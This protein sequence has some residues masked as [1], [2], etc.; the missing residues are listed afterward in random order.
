MTAPLEIEVEVHSHTVSVEVD[1]PV[2]QVELSPDPVVIFAATPGPPGP[3]GTGSDGF[4]YTQASPAATWTIS[5]TLGRFPR[6]VAVF[7][8][9]ELVEADVDTPDINTIVITFSSPQSGRA[10]IT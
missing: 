4:T 6:G 3:P 1:A 9:N 10:E 8:G 7:V 5:N 2:T